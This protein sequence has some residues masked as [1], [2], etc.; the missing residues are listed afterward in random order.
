MTAKNTIRILA[1]IHKNKTIKARWWALLGCT[2]SW[3]C[4]YIENHTY[5]RVMNKPGIHSQPACLISLGIL[6]KSWSIRCSYAPR[7]GN[8]FVPVGRLYGHQWEIPYASPLLIPTWVYMSTQY[9]ILNLVTMET[10]WWIWTMH[11]VKLSV[12]GLQPHLLHAI[13]IYPLGCVKHPLGCYFFSS[14]I[15]GESVGTSQ[16]DPILR[17]AWSKVTILLILIETYN[18]LTTNSFTYFGVF[19]C[20]SVLGI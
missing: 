15:A 12:H 5:Y 3:L 20:W 13:N 9:P 7:V 8:W 16:P 14:I 1:T 19:R 4:T 6:E 17:H 10:T 2:P 11:I 18:K